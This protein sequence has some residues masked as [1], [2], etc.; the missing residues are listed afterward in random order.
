MRIAV[1]VFGQPRFY[2]QTA[3]SFKTE[4]YDFPGH[5]TDV[6]MHCWSEVGSTPD[7]D[8]DNCNEKKDAENLKEDIWKSYK[9]EKS[10]NHLSVVVENP[11]ENFGAIC[12]SLAHVLGT[13][14]HDKWLDD[15]SDDW[16]KHLSKLRIGTA[17]EDSDKTTIRIGNGRVLRY[18]MG[19]LYSMG[20][21]I[22]LK[23]W[24]EK[25]NNFKYDLVIKVRT[26]AIFPPKEAFENEEEYYKEKEDY[27]LQGIRKNKRGVFGY[28]LNLIMGVGNGVTVAGGRPDTGMIVGIEA[29]E[30]ENGQI[31]NII[32]QEKR[33]PYVDLYKDSLLDD[34]GMFNFPFKL[35]HK[36]W[37]MFAD[38]ES[39][40]LAWST[41]VSTYISFIARDIN[42]FTGRKELPYMPGGEVLHA[43]AALFNDVNMYYVK[44][45]TAKNTFIKL[46]KLKRVIK[47]VHKDPDK[48]KG[49]FK[50]DDI[51]EQMGHGYLPVD[52][53][54]NMIKTFMDGLKYDD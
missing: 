32:P 20:K 24:Y 10:K 7:D 19:Q 51:V 35:H 41:M 33:F 8:W 53:L 54:E 14:R 5:E 42:R 2:K 15:T 21:A 30:I 31:T 3:E 13:L 40:D 52:N 26:D 27:Y 28:G 11:E 25:E 1:C 44:G 6:F 9:N 17:Y 43:G 49:P 23:S 50:S 36:D 48:R 37:L 45:G 47:V 39:A 18:E 12:D 4:F 38:S 34:V 16:R 46:L 29:I 22:E